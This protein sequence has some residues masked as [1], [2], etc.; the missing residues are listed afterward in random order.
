[1]SGQYPL[2]GREAVEKLVWKSREA[3]YGL[4]RSALYWFITTLPVMKDLSFEEFRLGYMCLFKHK[5]NRALVVLY[6][7]DLLVFA[8]DDTIIE[9]IAKELGERYELKEVGE[10]KRFLGFGVIRDY[11]TE[12]Q[13]PSFFRGKPTLRPCLPSSAMKI[14]PR[15]RR[16]GPRTLSCQLERPSEGLQ[17]QTDKTGR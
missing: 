5:E 2:A 1:M 14:S 8:E 12:R 10:V 15:L 16:L 9:A 6:V 13:G 4:R 3:L 17:L 11:G 7:D